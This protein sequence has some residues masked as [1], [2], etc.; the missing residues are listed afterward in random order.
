VLAILVTHP[1]QY[2]VPL[3]QM[4]ARDGRVPFEVWYL[5]GRGAKV[6]HDRDFGKSF[7]WDLEM[8]SGYPHRF[9]NVASDATPNSFWKCRLQESLATRIQNTKIKA[10]WVQGW[11][12]A[13][14]WQGVWAAKQDG[15]EVWLR[16]ESNDLAPKPFWKRVVKQLLLGQL[17]R[18]VDRFLFIGTGNRRLYEKFGVPNDRLYP[19]PYAV[20]NDRF[21]LQAET[22]RDQRS[23]IRRQWEIPEDAFCVLFCGKFIPKKRPQD[24]IKAAQLL[25]KAPPELK[26]HLLF[27]GSGELG[28]ELRANCNVIFDADASER[29]EDRDQRSEIWSENPSSQLLAP[30]FGN[31]RAS[32]AG[33]LN[34]TEISKAYVAADVL[35]LPSDY[36]ETWGLVVNEAM[37]SGTPCLISDHCGSAEDLGG[38]EPNQVFSCGDHVALA[39]ALARIVGCDRLVKV[40]PPPSLTETLDTV[41]QLTS[42]WKT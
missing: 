42:D 2:H 28:A 1:I 31:P 38:I 11:D 12:V 25:L 40:K 30:S 5:T 21:A 13:G 19:A 15:V 29:S 18:R 37:A 32:F 33:F 14:Y 17:F 7:A 23:E 35:V 24:L 26:I 8:L 39:D 9:L 4:L 34:Q 16:G 10:L 27:V 20:D 36:G 22:I 6:R 41:L 3:W